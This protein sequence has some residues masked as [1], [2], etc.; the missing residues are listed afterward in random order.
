MNN[1]RVGK[2]IKVTFFFSFPLDASAMVVIDLVGVG[3]FLYQ[4]VSSQRKCDVILLRY[5]AL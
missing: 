5:Y 2:G 1:S 4:N 3:I